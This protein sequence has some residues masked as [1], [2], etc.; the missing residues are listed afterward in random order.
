MKIKQQIRKQLS[1]PTSENYSGCQFQA[2][3]RFW[4]TEVY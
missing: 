2:P 3:V 4:D 1:T